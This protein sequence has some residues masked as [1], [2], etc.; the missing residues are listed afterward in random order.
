MLWYLIYQSK[1]YNRKHKRKTEGNHL[2]CAQ[3]RAHLHL[4]SA[5]PSF[6][7]VVFY[8]AHP[9]SSLEQQSTAATTPRRLDV[10]GVHGPPLL[11]TETR[12]ARRVTSPS[13]LVVSRPL[14]AFPKPT[15]RR[16][17][18]SSTGNATNARAG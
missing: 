17:S 2:P 15:E 18:S 10:P 14:H 7:L 3:A 4:A 5:Q 6:P 13:F 1:T 16:C 9:S 12:R 8:P 11:A